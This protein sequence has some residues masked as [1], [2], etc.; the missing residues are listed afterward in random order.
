MIFD[1]SGQL[2][3]VTGG[4]RGIG[5]AISDAFLASGARVI[6]TYGRDGKAA[7]EFSK[8]NP[9]GRLSTV[10][11][12]VSSY[13]EVEAFFRSLEEKGDSVSVLV[14]NAG[15]RRDSIVGMMK[16]DDWKSV[17]DTNLSGTF[18]MCK[19]GVLNMM[20]QRYGR[21]INLTSAGREAGFEGQANYSATKAGIVGF[22]KSLSKEVARR[23]ITVNCVSPGFIETELIKDLPA[24]QVAEYQKL[25]PLKRFGKAE[26]V[27]P[28]V[29]FLA[30]KEAG[31]ITGSIYDVNGGL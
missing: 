31:Y 16:Q 10:K 1:F 11:C 29:L 3:I 27:A 12:D 15:I 30:S 21:I 14:N 5:R 8:A 26:E 9:S 22:T 2:V 28:V 4:T 6:A 23:K 20:R 24:D 19:F 7:G 17:V 18:H 13:S 25:I